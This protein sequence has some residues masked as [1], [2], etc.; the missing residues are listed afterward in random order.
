MAG[1]VRRLSRLVFVLLTAVA[2]GRVASAQALADSAANPEDPT[3]AKD[4]MGRLLNRGGAPPPER[5]SR[6]AIWLRIPFIASSPGTGTLL[7]GGTEVTFFQGDP[8]TTHASTMVGNVAASFSGRMVAGV[9]LSIHGADNRWM[10]FG[11][12]RFERMAQNSY[13]LGTTSVP[14]GRFAADYSLPRVND[15]ALRRVYKGLYAG[16][17]FHFSHHNNVEPADASAGAWDSSAYVQYSRDHGF[18]LR[19]QGSAGTSA[20]VRF[21]NRDSSVN[22][23]RG[24]LLAASYRSFYQGFLGGD[25]TWQQVNLDVR[26]YRMIGG[27]PRHVLAMW[28]YADLVTGGVAP[29]FDLPATGMDM[30]G[31]SGRGYAVG[32]F[33]GE[34]LVYGEVEYR[35]TLTRNGLVG[36]VAFLNT[37]TVSNSKTGEKL[38]ASV[39]PGAGVGLRLLADKFSRTRVCLDVA[40]GRYGSRGVYLALQEA[41]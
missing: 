1:L 23:S 8:A 32:R 9:R 20:N 19:G 17:G 2:L 26:G 24:V 30:Q 18:D 39:A 4:V 29:Y 38:F 33:R 37:T 12:N 16:L 25:S 41:F 22:A 31:R 11:D 27:T 36:L 34:R 35:T 13:G 10:L 15:V 21:D 5:D 3:D 6:K 40:V 7:G 28:A 14:A